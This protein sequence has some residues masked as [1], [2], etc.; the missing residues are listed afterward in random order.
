MTD[1]PAPRTLISKAANLLIDRADFGLGELRLGAF[2]VSVEPGMRAAGI[3]G[4]EGIGGRLTV[5]T[6]G[7]A[8]R[9]HSVNRVRGTLEVP[10]A[11]VVDARDV[12]RLL[13]RR[14]EVT[15]RD[16][17]KLLFVVWGGPRIIAALEEA[18][19]AA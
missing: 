18:R 19:G 10:I 4:K 12:S 2:P 13:S 11:E 9:A 3:A 6:A 1:A 8:F 17:R 5:T 14:L 15:L 7:L 16:G